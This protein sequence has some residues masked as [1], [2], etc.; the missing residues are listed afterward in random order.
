MTYRT[1][2][3]IYQTNVRIDLYFSQKILQASEK[4]KVDDISYPLYEKE[5]DKYAELFVGMNKLSELGING[6]E[7]LQNM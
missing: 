5:K 4:Y 7:K 1:F 6:T 3:Q 2:S